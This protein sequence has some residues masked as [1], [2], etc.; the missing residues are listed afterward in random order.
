MG[1]PATGPPVTISHIKSHDKREK[2]EKKK[3]L[4]IYLNSKERHEVSNV[5]LLLVQPLKKPLDIRNATP[6]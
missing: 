3:R 6:S 2:K 5:E 1:S 4:S